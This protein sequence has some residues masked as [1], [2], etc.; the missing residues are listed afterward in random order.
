MMSGDTKHE[1]PWSARNAWLQVTAS[2]LREKFIAKFEAGQQ[3][4]G[5][6][7]GAVTVRALLDEMEA[8][9]LDQLAYVRE[10]KRRLTIQ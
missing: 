1:L 10:L 6:D 7:I 2:S 4:H 9:A 5:G 3:E 8:E